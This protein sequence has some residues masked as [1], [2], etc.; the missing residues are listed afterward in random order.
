MSTTDRT[1]CGAG[2]FA[3]FSLWLGAPPEFGFVSLCDW[4]E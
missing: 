1:L 4:I 3:S 2:K